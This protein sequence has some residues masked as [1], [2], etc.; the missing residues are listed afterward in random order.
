[1][2][3][4]SPAVLSFSSGELA[5]LFN[6]RVDLEEYASGCRILENMIPLIEGP[7]MRR[8]GTRFVREVKDSTD[9]CGFL[10][11]QFNVEQAYVLEIGD[12][13]MRFYTDHGIVMNG[14]NP[15]ELA[16]PWT[17]ADLFDTDGNFLL[18]AVQSGDVLYITHIDGDYQP[19]KLTRSGALSW[20][21]AAFLG[22]GGPF[23]DIDPDQTTTIFSSGNTGSVTLTA[24][25]AIFTANHI[26][27]LILI[28]QK[29][30][31]DTE[32]WEP[33]KA[34]SA[35]TVRRVDN[36]NYQAVNTAS[37]GTITPTHTVGAVY[38]GD[39]GVQWTFLDA[40]YGWA[41]ITGVG[42]SGATATATV[43]SRLPN[44]CVGSGEASTRWAFGAWS[45]AEGWPTHVTFFRE[46][47][48]FARATTRE[49]WMSVAGDFE[50]FADRDDGGEVVAD[51]SISIVVA[52]DQVNR[53]E[54]LAPADVLL[55]GTA[56]AEFAVHEITT[57]EPLGPGNVRAD[58]NSSYGSRSVRPVRVGDAVLYVQKSG[59]KLR[60]LGYTIEKERYVS[61]NLN[62][63]SRHL[64]PKGKAITGLAY[65][66]EPH[67]VVW[68]LRSDGLL[69]G[70]TINANQ[71]RF[72][73]HRHVI[74]GAFGS[75]DA[76]VEA[77]EVMPNPDADA[78]ELWLIVKRTVNGSTKRYV[79]YLEPEWDSSEDIIEAFYVDS[80][81][82]YD[83]A[84]NA[85]LT[86]G[87]GATV[88][89]TAN[90]TF[91]AGSGVFVSGDVGK[92][93]RYRYTTTEEDEEGEEYTAYHTARALITSRTS[94]TVVKA[95]IVAAFPSTSAIAA[96]GWR[97][98]VTTIS[99]LDHLEGQTVDVLADGA[100]HPQ[101]TVTSGAITL[102]AAA[103]YVHIGL[104]C[105]CKLA[106]MKLEAGAADGTAQGKTKRVH[107]VNVR[108]I[109]TVGGKAGPNASKLDEILFRSP[110]DDMDEP[111]PAFTGD[112]ELPWNDG[113][114]KNGHLM[115]VNDQPLPATVAA[116]LP[117][118]V[119]QDR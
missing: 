48:T 86:P 80:G 68:A 60:D 19:Q 58:H 45:T 73:W 113:Y 7:A 3:K 110:A 77:I 75:G 71:R 82:T 59:R 89:G 94:A 103:A 88:A 15:L 24:S 117:Q 4:A 1:M 83:G 25:S 57:S 42:S 74:G 9:R 12:Q 16:T 90:V 106:P 65:Q 23:Q 93:I 53:I 14:T 112:K 13:Y 26:G 99:G 33:A 62:V 21:I 51:S 47:L 18:R 91:T 107:R 10:R 116:F 111:L 52:S 119:T 100:T 56:G 6:A 31:D 43:L 28:E 67:S 29:K 92:E 22:E 17:A 8:G 41:K 69:M 102:Q 72:G 105:P 38:D 63:T 11:F 40:G 2:A 66:Q 49:V 81:L 54:W 32:Q 97:I 5:P 114:S 61:A 84:E 87:T 55:V 20:S 101:R 108:L 46:R 115:Y 79:E 104:P 76:V 95:T 35:N 36:R 27:A 70:A 64:L 34:V 37:T 98:T 30:D 85:M 50:N 96:N 78:D 39:S 118:L 109:D 44:G